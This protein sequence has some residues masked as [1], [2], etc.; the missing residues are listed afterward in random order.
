MKKN[1]LKSIFIKISRMLGY[2][3]VDQNKF[4][5]PTL[6]KELNDNLSIIT[7][8]EITKLPINNKKTD[9]KSGIKIYKEKIAN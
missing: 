6:Q 3:I 5:S 7:E 2:E 4:Y 8:R 9:V 1:I